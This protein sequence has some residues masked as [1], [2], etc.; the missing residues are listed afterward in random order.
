[1]SR[2]HY[3]LSIDLVGRLV[4]VISGQ[5]LADFLRERLFRPL[6]MVDTAFEVPANRREHLAAVYW[7]PD[8][9]LP[10]A[11]LLQNFELWQQGY[12][13]RIEVSKTYPVD[14]PATFQRG[15]HGLFSTARDYLRFAQM[16]ANGGELDGLRYLSRSTIALMHANH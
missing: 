9:I 16:L 15:G 3:S 4:E 12:N 5:T 14:A 8:L 7:R 11:K 6:G 10:A 1:G 13:E 2:W